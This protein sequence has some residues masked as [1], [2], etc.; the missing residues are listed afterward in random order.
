ME[1]AQLYRASLLPLYVNTSFLVF[2]IHDYFITLEDEVGYICTQRRS[3][4]KYM[5]FWIRYYT[6]VL[7]ILDVCQVHLLARPGFATNRL[8]GILDPVSRVTGAIA[9]WSADIIL[10][11]RVYA[12]FQCSKK[13]AIFNAVLFMASISAFL[14]ILAV[15]VR[16]RT[17]SLDEGYGAS[18]PGCAVMREGIEWVQW[19]PAAI[20]E[21]LLFI[22]ALCRSIASTTSRIQGKRN[23]SLS[24]FIV[25]D[26]SCYFLVV[27]A[28]L[29]LTSITVAS[30]AGV[31]WLGF[32]PLH[33]V[34]GISSAR[35]LIQVPKFSNLSLEAGFNKSTCI[36]TLNFGRAPDTRYEDDTLHT[37]EESEIPSL[38]HTPMQTDV[39]QSGSLN[40]T[41]TSAPPTAQDAD[42]LSILSE[43][44]QQ[45]VCILKRAVFRLLGS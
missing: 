19:V 36:S 33:A 17:P 28:L 42:T 39:E 14:G 5:F 7:L 13:V 41:P 18:V 22:Q 24:A 37:A 30:S 12:L 16:G 9:L 38:N 29:I 10:Q 8:C 27:T 3:L 32:G 25:F 31:P 35:L 2:V 4:A 1:F 11:L 15:S 44:S 40:P 23:I 21:G 43:V 34:V 45:G 26:S 6:I 20:F